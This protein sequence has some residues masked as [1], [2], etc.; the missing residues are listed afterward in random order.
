MRRRVL[1]LWF[2]VAAA[3]PAAAQPA[4]VPAPA[5]A[6]ARPLVLG[7]GALPGGLHAPSGDTLPRGMFAAAALG[8][9]GWRSGL[10]GDDHRLSRGLG[11][12]GLAFA[13]TDVLTIALAL[14]G[15]YDRHSGVTPD[16][17]DN[18]VG[19]P[20]LI[21]RVAKAAGAAKLGGQVSLWA[22][23]EDAPSLAAEAITVEA[24]GLA[25]LR[26]GPGSV[27]F[28]AGFRLDNSAK[29]VDDPSQYRAHE[30]VSLG[31][32]EHHAVVGSAYV[33]MP[34]GKAF[35][36][37]EASLDLFVGG[38]DPP[39][40]L[41]RAGVHGGVHLGQVSLVVFAELA[42]V[43]A[44]DADD[45]MA[46]DFALIAYEPMITGGLGVQGRFGGGKARGPGLASHVKV[47]EDKQDVA[48][49]EYA[50]IIGAVTDE[51]GQPI[52][53]AAVTAKLRAHTA[54][55][56]TGPGGEYTITQIPIGKTVG[57]VTTLDD[58][59]VEVSVSAAERK[60]ARTTSTLIKG[61][62]QMAKLELPP[63]LEP[64]EL[65][66][67]VSDAATGKPIAGATVAIE[68]GGVKATSG[69][70]GTLSVQLV[71]G[72]YQATAAAPGRKPQTLD[73]IVDSHGVH[74]KNFELQKQR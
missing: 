59:A 22:P 21:A 43:P 63:L 71:P 36:G 48:V 53:G 29:S 14:D 68:P 28:S 42:K 17:D 31:V 7:H 3:A 25:S 65:R 19:D 69:V 52:A 54:T 58:T 18:Y 61:R 51:A 4:D 72:T 38:D 6:S 16:G 39:G 57:G 40:P 27:G 62:N 44:I 34:A 70:D 2:C 20:R 1:A 41:L 35:F 37:A 5:P 47:N 46:D 15:R 23:G 45:L 9:F 67:V 13:P 8:G 50:E 55:G 73:V 74:I 33:T 30:R 12:L 26:A 60:P 11:G 56:V 10:V 66:A 24:R 32:S 64:G 49:I